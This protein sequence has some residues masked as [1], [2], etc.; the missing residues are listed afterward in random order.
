MGWNPEPQDPVSQQGVGTC[1]GQRNGQHG[2]S[3]PATGMSKAMDMAAQMGGDQYTR[4]SQRE[5]TQNPLGSNL[6]NLE[7][8]VRDQGPHMVALQLLGGQDPVVDRQGSCGDGRRRRWSRWRMT[9]T[10]GHRVQVARQVADVV[11]K[12]REVGRCCTGSRCRR[13]SWRRRLEA[14]RCP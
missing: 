9:Q 6:S 4:V 5:V 10:V 11:R 2:L 7:L 8:G 14:A 12:L 13:A 1:G 3:G